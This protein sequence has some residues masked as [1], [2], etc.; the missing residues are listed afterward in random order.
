MSNILIKNIQALFQ[1]GENFPAFLKGKEMDNVPQIQ[2]AFVLIENGLIKD[3]GSMKDAPSMFHETNIFETID[4][5]GKFVLPCFI[6]SHTHIVFAKY[7]E[8]EF[9]DR[10]NGLSY[11]D[12]AKKGGGI[13][14]SAQKL[15]SS[16]EEFLFN[17]SMERINLIKKYGTGAVEIKSGYGLSPDAE[18]KMLRVIKKIKEKSTL[19][20]KATFLGAH[21]IPLEY[22]NNTE[23]YVDLIIEKML[24]IVAEEQLADFVDV[25]CERNYFSVKQMEKILIATDKVGLRSKVHVNQFSS[26]GGIQKAVELKS[27][28]VDHL[29]VMENEDYQALKRSN[30]IATLLPACSY[31]INIPYANAKKFLKK[32]IPFCLASDFNPGST[33]TGN[34]QFVMSLACTQMKLTPEQALNAMTINAAYSMGLQNE[35]GTISKGKKAKLILTNSIPSLAYIPYAFG[36]NHIENTIGF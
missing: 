28:S 29:E 16:S 8:E 19:D 35:L 3:Y 2:N 23:K 11:E 7:R 34:M 30:T 36:Q 26:L 9:V 5:N 32:D 10:I 18:I 20:V 12:I 6:D 24:P 17:F 13:L 31:F 1:C 4:A 15:A 25:F 22:K 14:N 27:L 21:A 33:P